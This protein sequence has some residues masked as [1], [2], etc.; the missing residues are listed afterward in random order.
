MHQWTC[1]V[2]DT[3][4]DICSN[5]FIQYWMQSRKKKIR[6]YYFFSFSALAGKSDNAFDILEYPLL[7][8]RSFRSR[9]HL[10][11]RF[12]VSIFRDSMCT[13]IFPSCW[14]E[15]TVGEIYRRKTSL[16]EATLTLSCPSFVFVE[17]V[18]ISLV[19]TLFEFVLRAK[20]KYEIS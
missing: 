14:Y 12:I 9:I 15:V 5:H 19:A 17:R 10:V 18:L 3:A 2:H 7:V 6:G 4:I 20:R 8:D 16:R 13:T 11:C 1:R